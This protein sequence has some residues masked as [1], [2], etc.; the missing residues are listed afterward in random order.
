[1]RKNIVFFLQIFSRKGDVGKQLFVLY[2]LQT[3]A[4]FGFLKIGNSERILRNLC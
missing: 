3:A 2:I 1:M 4:F